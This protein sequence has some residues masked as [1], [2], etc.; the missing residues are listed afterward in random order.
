MTVKIEEVPH[1]YMALR[2]RW[3]DRDER[4]AIMDSVVKGDWTEVDPTDEGVENRSPNLVQVALEDTAEAA[5]LMPSLR[6]TPSRPTDAAKKAA[7]EMEKIGTSYLDQSQFSLLTIRSLLDLAGF[8]LHVWTILMDPDF[9]G[10]VIQWRDPRTC[11]PEPGYQ[12]GDPIK[13]CV[14]ARNVYIHQLS[15][16]YQRKVMAS[17]PNIDFNTQAGMNHAINLVE[18]YDEG[19]ILIAA[20]VANGSKIGSYAQKITVAWTPIELERISNQTG[21]CQVVIG[22]RITLDGEPRGQFDQVVPVMRAHIRLMSMVIDY[23]DQAVYSDIWVKD[24]I[25][26]MPYG[27]GAYIQL[28]S[29]GAIGRVPPAVNSFTVQHEL[30]ALVSNIHLGGRWPKSRPGEID[31]AIASAKFIEATTGMMNT[32]IRTYHLILKA[33]LEQALRVAFKLDQT[34]GAQRTVAGIRKNQ[35][36]LLEY[37]PRKLDMKAAVRVEYGLGLGRDP[38]QSMVLGI[39]AQGAGLVSRAFVQENFEGINDVERERGR[40]D[41]EQFEEMAKAGLLAGLQD[42]SIPPSALVDIAKAR[43]TGASLISLYEKYVAKPQTDMQ[44]QVMG[45]GLPGG[46]P[47][48]PG[49]MGP[50]GPTPPSA[51]DGGGLL[52]SLAGG[53]PAMP[54]SQPK[55]QSRLSVPLPGRGSFAG[56]SIG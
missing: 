56:T 6:M 43:E 50:G 18:V 24:L 37:E 33:S 26:E 49:Q 8:G 36:F 21:M 7:G 5:S 14:F 29:T 15:A 35:Q 42:K 22:N 41:V 20:M 31:Q 9:G 48:M 23:A 38:A 30:E 10:P 17:M 27:G 53:T 3:V 32:V 11:Y 13:R 28:A 40:L 47:V 39:Q 25:G 19:E 54:D 46:G 2:Q 16:V 55:A 52:A 4:I 45:S 34:H 51:P 1:L 12:P 44:A